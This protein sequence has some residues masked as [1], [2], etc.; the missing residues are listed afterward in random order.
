MYLYTTA[1][2]SRIM[3]IVLSSQL[4]ILLSPR[5]F[6]LFLLLLFLSLSLSLS[7]SDG[8]S[9]S[10]AVVWSLCSFCFQL[11]FSQ[12]PLVSQARTKLFRQLALQ[13]RILLPIWDR[14]QA[15]RIERTF[16]G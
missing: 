13:P 9:L 14:V 4:H 10:D 2:V 6:L 15:I 11:Q 16:G 7:L 1:N 5:L 3:I 8:S 12:L